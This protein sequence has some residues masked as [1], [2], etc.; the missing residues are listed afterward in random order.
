MATDFP[1]EFSDRP[2]RPALGTALARLRGL[3]AAR[4]AKRGSLYLALLMQALGAFFFVGELWSEILG[5]RSAPIPYEWQEMIQLLASAGLVI[6]LV[7]SA[8]YLRRSQRR[9][10]ELS[11]Q[12]DVAAGNFSQHIEQ[13]FDDWEFSE[14]ERSVALYAMKG[15]SNAEIAQL[16]GT[17][18]STVK[19]QMN[20]VYRKCGFGNRQQLIA[21]LVE[22]LFEGV[23][24]PQPAAPPRAPR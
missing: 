4:I 7:V 9:E 15:F 22:E 23:A 16:R 21:F 20:A 24:L 17:S 5:L 2:E 1:A 3:D 18:A 8:L 11:R 10:V 6:G 13:L 14:S 19:S 12:I